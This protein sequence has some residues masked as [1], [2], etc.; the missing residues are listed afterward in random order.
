MSA[1]ASATTLNQVSYSRWKCRLDLAVQFACQAA[2]QLKNIHALGAA[3]LS[4]G[5]ASSDLV[6]D[7]CRLHAFVA[8]L[9]SY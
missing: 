1:S 2:G 5:K 9:A 7:L 6:G 8:R 3:F 4:Q